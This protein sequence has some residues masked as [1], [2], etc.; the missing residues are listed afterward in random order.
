MVPEPPGRPGEGSGRASL[1]CRPVS[2]S[3]HRRLEPPAGAHHGTSLLPVVPAPSTLCASRWLLQGPVSGGYKPRRPR[4]ERTGTLQSFRAPDRGLPVPPPFLRSHPRALRP[5]IDSAQP[6]VFSSQGY[7]G[8]SSG[9]RTFHHPIGNPVPISCH[10]H[11]SPS[12]HE[13]ISCPWMGLFWM[14]NTR[15]LT[16]RVA[17]RVW[18]PL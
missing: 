12:P 2:S 6:C 14:F 9:S 16:L 4:C 8:T 13:P 18:F 11:S 7:A 5:L 15:G 1:C 10:P 17:S 3:E